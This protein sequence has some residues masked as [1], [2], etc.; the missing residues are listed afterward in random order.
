M[1]NA[2]HTVS[3]SDSGYTLEF[4]Q[5]PSRI[6]GARMSKIEKRLF[7]VGCARSG[8]TLVQAMLASH[9]HIHAF[10]ETFFF[11]DGG[12]SGTPRLSPMA[13]IRAHRIARYALQN[14]L[15]RLG[16]EHALVA[17]LSTRTR[18]VETFVH[19]LDR[20]ALASGCAIWS[21]K[22]PGHVNCIGEIQRLVPGALFV[23]V[24]RDG[25]DVVAS[26]ESIYRE[27]VLASCVGGAAWP[28]HES[29][30]R[31]NK[32]IAISESHLGEPGHFFVDYESLLREPEM[33]LK[34]LCHFI[35]VEYQPAMAQYYFHASTVLGG[36]IDDSWRRDVLR[37]L[38]STHLK[39]YSV[40]F[41]ESEQQ[42]LEQKL[43][44]QGRVSG[45]Q[46]EI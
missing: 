24:L 38:Q 28:L 46:R 41:T 11:L 13:Q 10:P 32:A 22:T 25:R 42:L 19:T 30:S 43:T 39:K 7:V 20:M 12:F 17:K 21:E 6:P 45:I 2:Q 14:A 5:Y 37:P 23:H 44:R 4:A 27:K 33:T 1:L 36:D 3:N 9:S 16:E 8:T 15:H 40:L 26:L 31:W 29:I 34:K 35:E 18:L